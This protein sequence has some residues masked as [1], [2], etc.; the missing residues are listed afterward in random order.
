VL[1]TLYLPAPTQPANDNPRDWA[2]AAAEVRR[3]S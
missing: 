3:P 1:Q 2:Q